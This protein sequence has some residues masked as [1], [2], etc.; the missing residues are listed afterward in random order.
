MMNE[1]SNV[2]YTTHYNPT[3]S[4]VVGDCVY[5]REIAGLP[6]YERSSHNTVLVG[7]VVSVPSGEDPYLG[8]KVSGYLG[9]GKILTEYAPR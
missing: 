6:F 9:L 2:M 7:I 1:S 5:Y 4:W 8:Y 3:D